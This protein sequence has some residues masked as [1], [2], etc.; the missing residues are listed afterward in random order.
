[1]ISNAVKKI[2]LPRNN[3]LKKTAGD[4]TNSESS[5]PRTASKVPTSDPA[6]F[7]HV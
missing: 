6:M 3:K 4:N 2:A 1:M 5:F 7:F